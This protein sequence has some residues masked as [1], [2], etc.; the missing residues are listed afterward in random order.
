MGHD[1]ERQ[2]TGLKSRQFR[3]LEVR[4]PARLDS[5]LSAR[6]PSASPVDLGLWGRELAPQ[7]AFTSHTIPISSGPFEQ[8][9]SPAFSQDKG[10][11]DET[12]D[13]TRNSPPESAAH[14]GVNRGE[15]SHIGT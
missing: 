9:L 12:G 5:E 8:K 2:G 13:V 14:A 10:R 4:C 11:L 6:S 15:F 3:Y 1:P 7:P